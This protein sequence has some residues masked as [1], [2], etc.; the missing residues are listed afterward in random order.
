MATMGLITDPPRKKAVR[1]DV[2]SPRNIRRLVEVVLNITGKIKS[3]E[4]PT[5]DWKLIIIPMRVAL[6]K[7]ERI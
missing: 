3:A 6:F 7:D 5:T 2:I 1:P 4:N